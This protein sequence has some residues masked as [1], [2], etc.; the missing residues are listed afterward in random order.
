MIYLT[1]EYFNFQ[2]IFTLSMKI[3][4][5]YRQNNTS[6]ITP[7]IINISVNEVED[8]QIIKNLIKQNDVIEKRIRRKDKNIKNRFYY[9]NIALIVDNVEYIKDPT[10]TIHITGKISNSDYQNIKEGSK[11]S[12]WITDGC[13]FRLFKNEWNEEEL[14]ILDDLINY[15]ESEMNYKNLASP[16]DLQNKCFDILHKYITKNFSYVT[17]GNETLNTLEM[18]AIKVLFVTIEFIERQSEEWKYILTSSSRKYHGANIVIYDKK[19]E[20]WDELTN[21]GGVIGVLKYNIEQS[22]E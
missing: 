4:I 2:F 5:L 3:E 20:N 21:Y 8:Y 15:D 11:H 16:R 18:G 6:K 14:R 12:I 19:S 17:Y 22:D 7:S 9:I 1:I 13:E 10:E